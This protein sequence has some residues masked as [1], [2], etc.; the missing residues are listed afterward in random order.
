[1]EDVPKNAC[2]GVNNG[3]P[4]DLI[5]C[6]RPLAPHGAHLSI[7]RSVK[8]IIQYP[9][10]AAQYKNLSRLRRT[11]EVLGKEKRAACERP[12][13]SVCALCY[14]VPVNEVP[15]TY[16]VQPLEMTLAASPINSVT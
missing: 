8:L 14:F 4:R 1:M 13:C 11:A 16:S 12:F 5:A 9:P 15:F 7:L 3:F 6:F 2:R 10:A